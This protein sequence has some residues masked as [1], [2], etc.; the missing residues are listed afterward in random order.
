MDWG[1]V[2][3][4]QTTVVSRWLVMPMAATSEAVSFA[5]ASARRTVSS[6]LRHRSRAH[7]P[8][9]DR[10]STVELLLSDAA[11]GKPIVEHDGAVEVVLVDGDDVTLASRSPV[12]SERLLGVFVPLFCSV[13]GVGEPRLHVRIQ[14]ARLLFRQP[15]AQLLRRQRTSSA[16]FAHSRSINSTP[17]LP[18]D[19]ARRRYRGRR[20]AASFRKRSNPFRSADQRV[21]APLRKVCRDISA[22][23]C[24]S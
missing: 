16:V 15:Q 19:H 5:S 17:P 7:V 22:L 8:Q 1:A 20:E 24:W 2:S 10:E 11:N 18:S 4:S 9:P 21:A 14:V 23:I 6:A 13:C 3:R 12:F